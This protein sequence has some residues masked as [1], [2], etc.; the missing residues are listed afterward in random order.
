MRSSRLLVAA[1]FLI[2][3]LLWIG[4]GS[5]L[6]EGSAMSGNPLWEAVGVVLV[7]V[8]LAIAA[9]EWLGRPHSRS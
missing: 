5:A 3:G 8:G 4:Q 9:R 6:I 7:V 2:I 1:L